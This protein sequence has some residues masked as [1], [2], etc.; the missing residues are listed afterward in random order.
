MEGLRFAFYGR[1][2]TVEFQDRETSL[3][4]Q[5]EVAEET[6][7]GRGVVVAEYFDEAC[8]RRLRGESG[9]PLQCCWQRYRARIASSTRSWWGSTSVRSMAISSVPCWR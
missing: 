1:T 7:G 2:S 5:R 4:W 6:I 9:R 3:R 8:S